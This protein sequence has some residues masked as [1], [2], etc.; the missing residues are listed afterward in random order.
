MASLRFFF[1]TMGSG[2]S[3]M[4]LQINHN[5]AAHSSGLMLTQHDREGASVSSALGVS[6]AA[7]EV[8]PGLDLFE[9]A[10]A[11][12]RAEGA[13]EY[14]VC[15]EAQ[16]YECGQVDQLVRVVD[17]LG[18]D[19]YAFGLITDFRGRLFPAT[20][21]LL[22]VADERQQL[23]VQAPLLVRRGSH[24]QCPRRRR[25]PGLRRRCGGDRRRHHG[26][27]RAEVPAPLGQRPGCA[28]GGRLH[29]VGRLTGA[30]QQP[31]R[32]TS[33]VRRSSEP[34]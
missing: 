15:D 2:K 28:D 13:L 25:A 11:H 27:L 23:Q 6:A 19:V 9:V 18:A 1:G 20:S 31:G 7:R 5:L 24:P 34:A 33:G 3:T 17:D 16:F 14:L 8:H 21:R 12:R 32:H 30:G 26:H 22:E 10:D 4:A 29:P